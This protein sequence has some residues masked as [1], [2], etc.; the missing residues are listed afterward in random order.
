MNP[1]GVC[2]ARAE[3]VAVGFDAAGEARL[4]MGSEP[5]LLG[6]SARVLRARRPPTSDDGFDLAAYAAAHPAN[7]PL[8]RH[9]VYAEGRAPE[10]TRDEILRV[11]RLTPQP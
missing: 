6:A 7:R 1:G 8:A 10:E 4:R 2:P 3:V 5:A 11:A 9:V